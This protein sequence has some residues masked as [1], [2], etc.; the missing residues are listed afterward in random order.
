M[1]AAF[2]RRHHRLVATVLAHLDAECL[3]NHRC[4]FGGGTAI[5]LRHGE[6]RESR[7][8]DFLVSDIDCYRNLRK[9][10]SSSEGLQP[11]LAD[12][13]GMEQ[14]RA[15]RSDQYGI[16]TTLDVEGM[17]IKLE[18]VFEARI[19]LDTPAKSDRL[20]GVATLTGVDMAA[21]KL[22]A[23]AD[24]RADPG[25]F[26]RDV[27]DLAMLDLTAGQWAAALGKAE[28]AYGDAVRTDV[29]RAIEALSTRDDRLDRCLQALSITMPKAL[30][31]ERLRT[32]ERRCTTSPAGRKA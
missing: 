27:I 28:S 14:S 5:V 9:L 12:A 6:Y 23:N 19:D 32:L 29:R 3:D 22:L 4:Y 18:I 10:L 11:I 20:Q 24:R 21:T 16:R 7:D 1:N 8:M 30:V 15:I 2:E 17:P 31:W 13:P 26:S 25:T